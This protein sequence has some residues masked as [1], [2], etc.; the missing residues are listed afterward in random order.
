MDNPLVRKNRKTGEAKIYHAQTQSLNDLCRKARGT[1]TSINKLAST[2]KI[3]Q[4]LTPELNE[5]F[6]TQ[7]LILVEGQEDAAYLT[8]YFHLCGMWDEFRRL[9]CHIVPTNSKSRMLQ[10]RAIARLLQIPTFTIFDSD[11]DEYADKSKNNHTMHLND[12][13]ALLWICE[14]ADS[15]AFPPSHLWLQGCTVWSSNIGK[16]FFADVSYE[17]LHPIKEQLEKDYGQPGDMKKNV[18]FI[19]DLLA[20]AW[21]S[22]VRSALLQR[23]CGD[24]L[25]F[26]RISHDIHESPCD[27]QTA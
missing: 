10:P 7:T 11:G 2:A 18:L 8:T 20:L 16:A 17:R 3:H 15:D 19:S 9:G 27:Q 24:I 22:D 25:T 21:E 5:M 1:G 14:H 23:L 13:T 26:A 6:F 4:A 12:N